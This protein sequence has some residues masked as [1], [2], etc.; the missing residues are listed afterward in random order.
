MVE[1]R[2][3]SAL[4]RIS[5]LVTDGYLWLP[6][7]TESRVLDF[8]AVVFAKHR[9]LLLQVATI[10][11]KSQL[12]ATTGVAISTRAL[13]RVFKEQERT[14]LN[15][16]TSHYCMICKEV[17]TCQILKCLRETVGALKQKLFGDLDVGAE[18]FAEDGDQVLVH[19]A[20]VVVDV[21]ADYFF[22]G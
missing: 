12:V 4:S 14:G 18:L 11:Y 20:V 17:A 5:I 7:L 1:C 22:S 6:I 3:E 2:Q 21:D 10:S 9:E 8:R 19:E 13:V 15:R 16:A